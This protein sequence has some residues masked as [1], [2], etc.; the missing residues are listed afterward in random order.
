[1]TARDVLWKRLPCLLSCLTLSPIN[2]R[3]STR[4]MPNMPQAIARVTR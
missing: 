1:M 3:A 2:V 4:R